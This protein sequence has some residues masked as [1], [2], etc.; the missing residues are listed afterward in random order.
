VVE[1]R[2]RDAAA[3]H[4]DVS[5]N[6][7]PVVDEARLAYHAPLIARIETGAI[8][9]RGKACDVDPD[10]AST[11][12]RHIQLTEYLNPQELPVIRTRNDDIAQVTLHILAFLAPPPANLGYENMDVC[13]IEF[14]LV[15][16][17]ITEAIRA[18]LLKRRNSVD[19]EGSC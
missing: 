5:F 16:T 11:R 2:V 14:E 19:L 15:G 7:V 4:P 1:A 10:L 8:T 3:K 9:E 12:W 17:W 6:P 13:L 18:L